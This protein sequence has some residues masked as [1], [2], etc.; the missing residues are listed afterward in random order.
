MSVLLSR[1]DNY[2]NLTCKLFFLLFSPTYRSHYTATYRIPLC[3]NSSVGSTSSCFVTFSL[4]SNLFSLSFFNSSS[5][6]PLTGQNFS[7]NQTNG[8]FCK[9]H[10]LLKNKSFAKDFAFSF[11]R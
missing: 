3:G 2:R 1:A 4:N 9:G 10:L 7:S 5:V 6:H 8:S 11:S